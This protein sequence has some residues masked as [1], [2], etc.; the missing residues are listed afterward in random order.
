MKVL[1]SS[2][3]S[4]EE[5]IGFENDIASLFN[6][7][8][9]RHPVHLESGNEDQLIEVFKDINRE[10]WV[11]CSWRSH[12]KCLLHGVPSDVLKAA[13]MRGESIALCFPEYRVLSS[14]IVGG[15]VSIAV[16]IALSI[17]RRGGVNRV[18][19]WLGDMTAATG[20]AHESIKYARGHDLP[21]RWIVEDNGYS[22]LTPT[23]EAWGT[24][25]YSNMVRYEYRSKWPHAG[26]GKRI[27]F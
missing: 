14:A 10:D 25:E 26:A 6:A 12:L 16:G 17:K 11:C 23:K 5:L 4:P 19:C 9:I 18:H 24:G 27:Q 1:K 13:I 2:S 7:G 20:I 15:V 3:M 21:I 22:V 8:G